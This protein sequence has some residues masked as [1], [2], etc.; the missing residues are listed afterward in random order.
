MNAERWLK[1]WNAVRRLRPW[2]DPVSYRPI[3]LLVVLSFA[4]FLGPVV[5]DVSKAL[6]SGIPSRVRWWFG[7]AAFLVLVA[8]GLRRLGRVLPTDSWPMDSGAD[9]PAIDTAAARWIPWVLRVAVLSLVFPIMKN[10]DGLGFADWDVVLD[11]FEALRR[12]ILI[13]GQFPW[14]NPWCRGGFPLAAEPQIGAVSIATPLVLG[15]GTTIGLRLSTILCLLI[16]V[17]GAYRLASLWFREPF[18]AAAATP[19][20]LRGLNN[21]TSVVMRPRPTS[22]P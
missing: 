2:F 11:K 12:T 19:D 18:S 8:A 20:P 22:S 13:W 16:A 4:V 21:T 1:L 5:Y 3:F 6:Y 17:E 14:W 10:P 7:E 15:L 9:G